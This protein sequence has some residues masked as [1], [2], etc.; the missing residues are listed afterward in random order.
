MYVSLQF[1][2]NINIFQQG[3]EKICPPLWKCIA[4]RQTDRQRILYSIQIDL[5]SSDCYL[6]SLD[7]F[8]RSQHDPGSQPNSFRVSTPNISAVIGS[9][10]GW[11]GGGCAKGA[12]YSLSI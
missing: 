11:G 9:M 5:L 3:A 8:H 10:V 7:C 4:Y 2:N 1:K 6:E 12:T